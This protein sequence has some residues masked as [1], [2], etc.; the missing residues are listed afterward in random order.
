MIGVTE[1][2]RKIQDLLA[3]A[4]ADAERP[5]EQIRLLAVSKKKPVEAILEAVAAGQRDF[6]ENFVQEGLEKIVSC[7]R[8][9]LVWHFI[10]HLQSNKTRL[11][12]EHFQWVHTIDRLKIDRAFVRDITSDPD[13]SAIAMAVIA[14]ASS[15]NLRVLA[16][17]VETEP[18][19]SFLQ[20]RQCDEMQGYHLGRPLPAPEV[21]RLVRDHESRGWQPQSRCEKPTLLVVD[22][23]TRTLD[24]LGA[25]LGS[26]HYEILTAGNAERGFEILAT[27]DVGV[28]LADYRMPGMKGDQ[29]LGRVRTLY[30]RATRIM[31]SSESNS[32]F[33][34]S[35]VNT[36]EIYKILEKPI[37]L[38]MLRKVVSEAFQLFERNG[39]D[40]QVADSPRT[41]SVG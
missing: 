15:M 7:G 29:F 28:V 26:E 25:A 13:D 3:K 38:P 41:A 35:A 18:Q 6:G 11:V 2:F 4:A 5:V 30:P 23:D 37:A 10:G 34:I 20:N 16:E 9:D 21:A 33:L 40:S 36:C 32:S 24:G 14:M 12:A 8:D 17:G 31:M 1:N 39:H 27:H 19:M 22:D